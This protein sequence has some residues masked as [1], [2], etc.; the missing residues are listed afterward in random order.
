MIIQ[1]KAEWQDMHREEQWRLFVQT[2]LW[3]FLPLNAQLG[4][5]HHPAAGYAFDKRVFPTPPSNKRG[6]PSNLS[7]I[8]PN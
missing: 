5:V 8:K 6:K 2:W 4:S 3:H 7:K 1:L